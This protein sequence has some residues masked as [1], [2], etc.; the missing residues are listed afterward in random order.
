MEHTMD[1]LP[2][3]SPRISLATHW[4]PSR[5]RVDRLLCDP[6]DQGSRAAEPPLG[7]LRVHRRG[8]DFWA[9]DEFYGRDGFYYGPCLAADDAV[10][11]TADSI[12]A[13]LWNWFN[14]GVFLYAIL[15]FYREV[16]A[17]RYPSF[18]LGAFLVLA[19]IGAARSIYA[20]QSNALIVGMILLASVE[21]VHRRWWRGVLPG[22]AGPHEDL[23]HRGSSAVVRAG[24]ETAHRAA[25]GGDCGAGRDAAD[26]ALARLRRALLRQ[27]EAQPRRA[28]RASRARPGYR[29][30][31]TLW[32]TAVGPVDKRVY[33]VVQLSVACSSS[34]GVWD[35]RGM[36]ES[37]ALMGT[38]GLWAGWQMLLGPG[39]ERLTL[40]ILAPAA[41]WLLVQSYQQKQ[42]RML[43]T[44]ACLLIFI[45]GTGEVERR[46]VHFIPWANATLPIGV[47]LFLLAAISSGTGLFGGQRLAV[48]SNNFRQRLPSSSALPAK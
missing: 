13:V 17:P 37:E 7:L 25:G 22:A 8:R 30:A 33:T 28:A 32:E 21:I 2:T 38:I 27:M 4:L 24:S 18:L 42:G 14:A 6:H 10:R 31:W 35:A 45:I 9:E 39:S 26:H 11:R 46:L 41:A 12:G 19:L 43:A 44:I 20:A 40:S 15:R 1:G 23:A 29:D 48:P 36:H 34:R 16:I 5:H 47:A 3:T